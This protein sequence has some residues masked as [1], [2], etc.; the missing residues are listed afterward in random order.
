MKFNIYICIIAYS[1]LVYF[2][3]ENQYTLISFVLHTLLT[4]ITA[5]IL[6]LLVMYFNSFPQIKENILIFTTKLLIYTLIL[7]LLRGLVIHFF[8][9]FY[10]DLVVDGFTNN[11]GVACTLWNPIFTHSPYYNA[12]TL[13]VI[14]KIFLLAC[15]GTF[16]TLNTSTIRRFSVAFI[17]IPNVILLIG[18]YIYDY[19]C[20]ARF[21]KVVVEEK[22][23]LKLDFDKNYLDSLKSGVQGYPLLICVVL[24]CE[25]FTRFIVFLR[26]RRKRKLRELRVMPTISA[27]VEWQHVEES[28]IENNHQ[29][30]ENSEEQLP[31]AQIPSQ[32]DIF[33]QTSS[34]HLNQNSYGMVILLM[35]CN[36][37]FPLGFAKFWSRN[38]TFRFIIEHVMNYMNYCTIYVIPLAW[39]VTQAHVKTFVIHKYKQL[40]ATYVGV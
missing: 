25:I 23:N 29:P 39:I 40:K 12:Q 38:Q 35:V 3:L 20:P 32:T 21:I 19:V 5:F 26:D 11:F 9:L 33:K 10:K 14:W 4:L 24:L 28:S 6:V 18:I 7:P 27:L 22:F 1:V 31:A 15:P 17:M 30:L 2:I 36:M 16:L 37:V 13:I 8:F 34:D